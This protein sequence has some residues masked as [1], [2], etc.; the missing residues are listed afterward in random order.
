MHQF[1]FNKFRSM[2][3][4]TLLLGSTYC[5]AAPMELTIPDLEQH[6]FT[7]KFIANQFGC[8]G[9][10]ISPQILWKNLPEQAKSLVLTMFDPDAPTGSGWWHWVIVNIPVSTQ[11]IVQSAGTHS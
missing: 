8:Q 9:E 5:I 2:L 3:F 4:G 1:N 11:S 7:A 6:G 10:N